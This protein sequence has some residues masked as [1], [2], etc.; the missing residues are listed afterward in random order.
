MEK[1]TLEE[2]KG[3]ANAFEVLQKNPKDFEQLINA[4]KEH[5][6]EKSREILEHLHIY[7]WCFWIYRWVCMFEKIPICRFFCEKIPLPKPVFND[8][9]QFAKATELLHRDEKLL[10]EALD[11]FDAAD[12]KRWA[13]VVERLHLVPHCH[14]I[15]HWVYIVVCWRECRLICRYYL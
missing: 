6:Y 12:N 9:L 15:C 10:T 5:Q 11:A 1:E 7:R 4:I 13:S 14:L 2:L 3:I 8:Y